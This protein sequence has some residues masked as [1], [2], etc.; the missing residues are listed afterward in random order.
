MERDAWLPVCSRKSAGRKK[1]NLQEYTV[2]EYIDSGDVAAVPIPWMV[3]DGVPTQTEF[4]AM[5]SVQDSAVRITSILPQKQLYYLFKLVTWYLGSTSWMTR[6][7]P[8][9]HGVQNALFWR[10]VWYTY[11]RDNGSVIGWFYARFAPSTIYHY[12]V[13]IGLRSLNEPSVLWC[14]IRLRLLLENA[15]PRILKH[16]YL[17][18]IN[19]VYSLLI[20]FSVLKWPW[21]W[22]LAF[23][24]SI[25]LSAM[26]LKPQG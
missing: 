17:K 5:Y 11:P 14:V 21:N 2:V 25:I 13:A 26:Q 3:K 10:V 18:R 6:V 16:R 20:T 7:E 4:M 24:M 22:A 1:E 9:S 23:L 8:S 15:K 19:T 12:H